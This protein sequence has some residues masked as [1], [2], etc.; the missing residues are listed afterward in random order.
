MEVRDKRVTGKLRT[1]ERN[2]EGRWTG[3]LRAG[4]V[5]LFAAVFLQ[6]L[7]RIADGFGQWYVTEIYPLLTGTL[8]RFCGFFPFSLS[9][10]GLYLLPCGALYGFYRLRREKKRF[11]AGCF[12]LA[13]ALFFSYTVCCGINYFCRPFSSYLEYQTGKYSA[14]ELEELLLWLTDKVNESSERLR[15]GQSGNGSS[16]GAQTGRNGN[17]LQEA[18]EA[19]AAQTAGGLSLENW[20]QQEELARLGVE[21]MKGLGESYPQLK[22][23]YPRPKPLVNSRFLSIQQLSGIYSPFTIEANY[24]REMTAYNIPHTIC[25]ELSHLRGF[26]RE[27]EANFIGFLACIGSVDER[28]RYSGYLTGWVYAGNA[29]AKENLDAYS[30]CWRALRPEVHEDLGENTEFWNRF[31]SEISEAAETVN[32]TYLKANRQSDGVKSYGRVVDLMLAWYGC[33]D[34]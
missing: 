28:Y 25:H 27:D 5:F 2:E 32:N 4:C 7:A 21:A 15:A 30:G 24:N 14:E 16:A 20:K 34:I 11:F 12:C 13:A 29:L 3:L 18:T 10:L 31:E 33:G 1:K 23:F 19:R 26:M 9:E 17:A 22:G 8:G 6:A